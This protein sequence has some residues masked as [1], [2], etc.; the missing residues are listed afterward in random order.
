MTVYNNNIIDASI[1][2]L[3]ECE[4]KGWSIRPGSLLTPT[5]SLIIYYEDSEKSLES[6]T[7]MMMI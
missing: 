3:K 5:A 4:V 7:L 1:I 2:F 6:L